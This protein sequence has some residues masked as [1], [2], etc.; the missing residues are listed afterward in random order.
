MYMGK[1]A[2]KKFDFKIRHIVFNPMQAN[3]W[4]KFLT[5]RSLRKEK[6]QPIR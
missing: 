1:L 5:S 2:I 4:S 6:A 3:L